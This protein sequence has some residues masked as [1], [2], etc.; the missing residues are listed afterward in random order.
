MPVE[1]P[2]EPS[3]KGNPS[4][5]SKHPESEVVGLFRR[6]SEQNRSYQLFV[7]GT[8]I[9]KSLEF[10]ERSV[11]VKYDNLGNLRRTFCCF[12][13]FNLLD[14]W[15]DILSREARIL[16]RLV[17]T[18]LTADKPFQIE[19]GEMPG[20]TLDE[21]KSRLV[22]ASQNVRYACLG[23]TDRVSELRLRDILGIEELLKALVHGFFFVHKFN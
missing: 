21:F 13:H 14:R 8:N 1:K 9:H 11:V 6:E 2:Q 12:W 18:T 17:H 10:P 5:E 19:T 7:H 4:S 20:Y 15:F 22:A 23:Y 16:K 3:E